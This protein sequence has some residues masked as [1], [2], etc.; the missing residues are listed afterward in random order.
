MTIE[1]IIMITYW[2][3]VFLAI[4][5]IKIHNKNEPMYYNKINPW[6]MSWSWIMILIMGISKVADF[7]EENGKDRFNKFFNY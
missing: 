6:S 4:P 1:V 7:W 3:G 2:S 5:L